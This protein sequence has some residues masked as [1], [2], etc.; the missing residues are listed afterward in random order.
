MP[1]VYAPPAVFGPN[2]AVIVGMPAFESRVSA[3]KLAPPWMNRSAWRGRS[4]PADSF[5]LISGSRF[6]R[7]IS[8]NRCPFFQVVGFAAP[9]LTLMSVPV[10]AHSTPS[11]TPM[12]WTTPTPTGSWVPQAG[13][14][15]QLEERRVRIDECLDPL[16]HEHLPALA[17][18][19]DVA[20]T[21]DRRDRLHHRGDLVPHRLH[22]CEVLPVVVGSRVQ[23][24]AK[25]CSD[26]HGGRR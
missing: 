2:A 24:R 19:V 17:V 1:G 21:A 18:A 16:A 14:R 22:R 3:L 15:R 12:P 9:P 8:W 10:I 11:I 26:A 7:A 23:L 13:E 20:L 25:R 6:S 5:R 4:A